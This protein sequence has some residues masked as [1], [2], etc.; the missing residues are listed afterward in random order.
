MCITPVN[1]KKERNFYVEEY[2]EIISMKLCVTR[3]INYIYCE[4]EF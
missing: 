2:L 4:L 1:S 3:D